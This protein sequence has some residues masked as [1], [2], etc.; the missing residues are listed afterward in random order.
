M[1]KFSFSVFKLCLLA[2]VLV[3]I[4]SCSRKVGCYFSYAPAIEMKERANVSTLETYPVEEIS[5]SATEMEPATTPC[6]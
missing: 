5:A 1:K 3:I 4:T 2:I 6:E